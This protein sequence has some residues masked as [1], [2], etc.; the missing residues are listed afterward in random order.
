MTTTGL[1][2]EAVTAAFAAVDVDGHQTRSPVHY[3]IKA[4]TAERG[5]NRHGVVGFNVRLLLAR[6]IAAGF[7]GFVGLGH[8]AVKG[9]RV[10]W[11]EFPQI[12]C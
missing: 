2:D 3:R 6:S 1:G 9:R 10:A 5:W 11:V 7:V 12:Y 4:G 8:R